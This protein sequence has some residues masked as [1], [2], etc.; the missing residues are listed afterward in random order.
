MRKP[1]ICMSE[2]LKTDEDQLCGNSEADQC[3]CF[4]YSESTI[5]LLLKSDIAVFCGCICQF[6]SDMFKTTLLV[7]S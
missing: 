7:F 1:T 3:L 2:K 5:A 4:H 6:V